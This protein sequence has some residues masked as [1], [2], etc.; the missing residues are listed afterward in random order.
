MTRL[1]LL[2]V[3]AALVA[4]FVL[5]AGSAPKAASA[6]AERARRGVALA[7]AEFGAD[8]PAFSNRNRGTHGQDFKY[9]GQRTYDQLAAQGVTLFRLPVRW[10]RLQPTLGGPLD[11]SELGR[12]K[13][14][15][16]RASKV[17]GEAVIDLHNYGR[18]V[19]EVGGLPYECAINER[20]DGTTPVT[21][22]HFADLWR[23]L[24]REFKGHPGVYAYGLM[25]EPHDQ[26]DWKGVSQAAVTAIRAEGDRT[27][28]LVPVTDWSAAHRFA[29]A[30]TARP[31]GS[32]TRPTTSSMRPTATWTG[33]P[34]ASTP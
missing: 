11:A 7:G 16:E 21:A 14:A 10:E 32:P 34:A 30:T 13:A 23:R 15:V 19:I 18:Y 24:A 26:A 4:G 25:N 22:D 28:I 12:L 9:K 27:R 29:A 31:P 1:L 6:Q 8:R 17:G 20:V 3:P 5:T 2:A 33:T